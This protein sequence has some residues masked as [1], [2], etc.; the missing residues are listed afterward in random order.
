MQMCEVQ[1]S[2]VT[3]TYKLNEN[4]LK[5]KVN[6]KIYFPQQLIKIHLNPQ[7]TFQ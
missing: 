7:L 6:F 1:M 2:T 5:N 4:L 3:T